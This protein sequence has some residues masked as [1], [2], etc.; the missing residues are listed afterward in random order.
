M[1]AHD[2]TP[3]ERWWFCA[4]VVAFNAKDTGS[5]ALYER[6]KAWYQ[7]EFPEADH[8]QYERAMSRIA[9]MARV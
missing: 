3:E 7:R 8:V 1:S 6:L 4:S 9:R 5:H 2:L